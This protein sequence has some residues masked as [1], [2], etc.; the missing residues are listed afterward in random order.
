MDVVKRVRDILTSDILP[1]R[2]ECGQDD[3]CRY[4]VSARAPPVNVNMPAWLG[5]DNTSSAGDSGDVESKRIVLLLGRVDGVLRW[6]GR[7]EV[8]GR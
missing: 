8:E 4:D 5:G 7:E 6:V 1:L 3:V 2:L